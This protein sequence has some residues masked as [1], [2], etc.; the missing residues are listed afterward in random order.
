MPRVIQKLVQNQDIQLV[1]LDFLLAR[2]VSNYGKGDLS[3]A[4]NLKGTPRLDQ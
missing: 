2:K 3:V 1:H 4:T